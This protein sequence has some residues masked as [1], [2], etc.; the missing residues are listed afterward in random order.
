[1]TEQPHPEPRLLGIL[2][3]S[4]VQKILAFGLGLFLG[5]GL[6]VSLDA[7]KYLPV[8]AAFGL[9]CFGFGIVLMQFVSFWRKREECIKKESESMSLWYKE[10]NE[11]E[12]E[13]SQWEQEK[14]DWQAK[15]DEWEAE[16]DLA[17]QKEV[18]R[19]L[20]EDAARRV[21]EQIERDTHSDEDK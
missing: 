19:L 10:L 6:A 20:A 21:G 4:D 14:E 1:M 13:R 11:L 8:A 16:K 12:E 3:D 17:V 5:V 15:R 7:T 2:R 9:L 18:L